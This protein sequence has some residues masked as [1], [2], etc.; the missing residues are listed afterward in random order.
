MLEGP[1]VLRPSFRGDSGDAS[2]RAGAPEGAEALRTRRR[3]QLQ[4]EDK[5]YRSRSRAH[6]DGN[7]KQL[8][9]WSP[10]PP[11]KRRKRTPRQKTD[12]WWRG[13]I[14]ATVREEKS[15]GSH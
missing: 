6:G 2:A 1:E 13:G 7:R 15:G 8:L 10:P 5:T 4:V 12:E 14:G 11:G 9:Y 3:G